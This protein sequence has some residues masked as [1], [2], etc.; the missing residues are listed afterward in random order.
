MMQ[1]SKS[2]LKWI[3]T[4]LTNI[5]IQQRRDGNGFIISTPPIVLK[6]TNE[7][8][9]AKLALEVNE[10]IDEYLSD[11]QDIDDIDIEDLQKYVFDKLNIT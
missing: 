4:Q 6:E 2:D 3:V 8:D 9:I 1:I 7:F 10:I 11:K 5:N